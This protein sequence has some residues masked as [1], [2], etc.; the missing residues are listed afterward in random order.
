[1]A[2]CRRKLLN[3]L[4]RP[5]SENAKTKR[6]FT[7]RGNCDENRRP[8]IDAVNTAGHCGRCHDC[9][10][11]LRVVLDGEERCAGCGASRRYVSHGWSRRALGADVGECRK[12][13]TA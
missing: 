4:T 9:G 7:K 6:S 2:G 5:L 13:V 3:S 10:Q 12:K 8:L 11:E 1:M